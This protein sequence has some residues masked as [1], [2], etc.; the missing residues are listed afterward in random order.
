MESNTDVNGNLNT[1]VDKKLIDGEP[2]WYFR[3]VFGEKFIK[4]FE[5]GRTIEDLIY[6]DGVDVFS[7]KE[8]ISNG[9]VLKVLI[10]DGSSQWMK[11]T[12]GEYDKIS[13]LEAYRIFGIVNM[14]DAVEKTFTIIDYTIEKRDINLNEILS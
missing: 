3:A 14:E 9:K 7:T 4:G 5:S 12:F 11:S 8:K 6:N 1:S 10:S 13:N 2:L